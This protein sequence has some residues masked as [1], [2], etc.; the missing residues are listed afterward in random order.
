MAEQNSTDG[1]RRYED[2]IKEVKDI[3]DQALAVALSGSLASFPGVL[4]VAHGG[5][6][7]LGFV[8]LVSNQ[9]N[10]SGVKIFRDSVGFQLQSYAVNCGELQSNARLISCTDAARDVGPQLRFSGKHSLSDPGIFAFGTIAGRKNSDIDNDYG[11]YLQFN[12]TKSDG[13][14]VEG[15]RLD[16]LSTFHIGDPLLTE[17]LSDISVKLHVAGGDIYLQSDP[18]AVDIDQFRLWLPNANGRLSGYKAAIGTVTEPIDAVYLSNNLNYHGGSVEHDNAAFGSASIELLASKIPNSSEPATWFAESAVRITVDNPGSTSQTEIARFNQIVGLTVSKNISAGLNNIVDGIGNNDVTNPQFITGD[19]LKYG[20]G[21]PNGIVFGPIGAIYARSDAITDDQILY[22]KTGDSYG[23]EGWD[24]IP[25]GGSGNKFC[26]SDVPPSDTTTCPY[27][28]DTINNMFWYWDPRAERDENGGVINGAWLST[29]IYTCNAQIRGTPGGAHPAELQ[30]GKAEK[31]YMYLSPTMSLTNLRG[32]FRRFNMHL[33]DYAATLHVENNGSDPTENYYLLDLV[34]L[35]K[36]QAQPFITGGMRS[37]WPGTRDPDDPRAGGTYTIR[38]FGHTYHPNLPV[39]LSIRGL[40]KKV[41]ESYLNIN[42]L[43][44]TGHKIVVDQSPAFPN[45]ILKDSQPDGAHGSFPLNNGFV[46]EVIGGTGVGQVR[47]IKTNK[48]NSVQY[49]GEKFLPALDATSVVSIHDAQ[50]KRIIGRISTRGNVYNKFT[51]TRYI[52]YTVDT[53]GFQDAKPDAP[54]FLYGAYTQSGTF[55]S[56]HPPESAK[57][58]LDVQ[59]FVETGAWATTYN[60]NAGGGVRPSDLWGSVQGRRELTD[61][62]WD[63]D[64]LPIQYIN[65]ADSDLSIYLD[66]FLRLVPT[67]NSSDINDS[68][69]AVILATRCDTIGNPGMI[70]GAVVVNFRLALPEQ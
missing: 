1:I 48:G 47:M 42:V 26:V 54:T 17:L 35:R 2:L 52:D 15:A 14:I 38:G 56:G 41:P 67:P 58:T 60:I 62:G 25:V 44:A 31:G 34:T 32:G 7:G 66:H 23:N 33:I 6:G 57:N 69:D 22:V 37:E 49:R 21:D 45:D 46:I 68:I 11:G 9:Y 24:N 53:N 43:S 65:G 63:P 18:L 12:T 5:T 13:T 36:R 16:A 55:D 27:W 4:D 30:Q 19:N 59:D 51:G 20:A 3:A 70:A 39:A 28:Y 64:V 10:I 40:D 50:Y 29:Q 61:P 8:D